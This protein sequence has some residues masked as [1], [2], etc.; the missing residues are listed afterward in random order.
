VAAV[1][2]NPEV[3]KDL[4]LMFLNRPGKPDEVAAATG[5]FDQLEKEHAKLVADLDEYAKTLGPKLAQRELERQ[6]KIAGLQTELEAYRELAKLRTP[7][8]E[9]ERQARIAKAQAA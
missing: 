3:V 8:A 4:F 7:R 5:M 9:Q 2:D 1:K 6:N